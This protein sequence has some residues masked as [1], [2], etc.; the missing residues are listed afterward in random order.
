MGREL[1]ADRAAGSRTRTGRSRR[2]RR[3][4]RRSGARRDGGPQA[5]D[6]LAA[7]LRHRDALHHQVGCRPSR[8]R[9]RR[10]RD[11][12]RCAALKPLSSEERDEPLGRLDRLVPLPSASNDQGRAFCHVGFLRDGGV[13]WRGDASTRLADIAP[14]RQRLRKAGVHGQESRASDAEPPPSRRCWR[15]PG[16]RAGWTLGSMPVVELHTVGTP[17]AASAG[18]RCSRR[19]CTAA[20]GTCWWRPRAAPRGI[21]SGTSTCSPNPDVELTV[22]GRTLPM[23]ARTATAEER[24][25]LW[26]AHHPRVPRAMRAISA[27]RRGRSPS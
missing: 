26:P 21:R 9:R 25:E 8:P 19:P 7:R 1:A 27:R 23:R 2:C 15:S 17:H 4:S 13:I 10:P 24:A 12:P 5:G 20:G 18:R 14:R 6:R 22:R 3:A 11:S 16:G